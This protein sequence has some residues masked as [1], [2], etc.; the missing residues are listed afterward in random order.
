LKCNKC[1][2][3]WKTD[4]NR[5]VSLTVCPFCQESLE[6]DDKPRRCESVKETLA[7]VMNMFGAEVL[8]SEKIVSLFADLAP[9]LN[10][11]RDLIKI[12]RDKGALEV[13][14]GA[15][16]SPPTEQS[17]AI[18]RAVENFRRLWIRKQSFPCST[19]LRERWGGR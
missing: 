7:A 10:D 13:L 15:L 14:K 5:S 12:I 9:T 18:K 11:E 6:K 8:L 1:N 4:A 17:V 16:N 2:S 3:K 19:S